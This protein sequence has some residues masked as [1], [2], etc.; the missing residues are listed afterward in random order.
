M[1]NENGTQKPYSSWQFRYIGTD[2][3]VNYITYAVSGAITS[4]VASTI[5]AIAIVLVL[6]GGL[7]LAYT[8][9]PS[10]VFFIISAV[11]A[12]DIALGF[13]VRAFLKRR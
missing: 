11:L 8:Y 5:T 3:W 12:A 7:W 6:L 2:R 4:V 10:D 13:V 9:L 1:T